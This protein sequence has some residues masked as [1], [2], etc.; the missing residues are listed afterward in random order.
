MDKLIS[1]GKKVFRKSPL[2]RKALYDSGLQL[3]PE[4]VLTRWGTWL[5]AADFYAKHFDQFKILVDTFDPNDAD[6]IRKI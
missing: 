4:P 1:L 5:A 6:A 2:R 3:P